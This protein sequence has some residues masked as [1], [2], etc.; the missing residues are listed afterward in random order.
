MTNQIRMF[1][2]CS[3]KSIGEY[4]TSLYSRYFYAIS[5]HITSYMKVKEKNIDIFHHLPTRPLQ[6]PAMS[7]TQELSCPWTTTKRA[8]NAY[9]H[10]IFFLEKKSFRQRKNSLLNC[11][12]CFEKII[13]LMLFFIREISTKITLYNTFKLVKLFTVVEFNC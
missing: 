12:L 1:C 10:F 4:I 13:Q 6:L 7:A 11:V 3:R 5:Q 2:V 9:N 8:T